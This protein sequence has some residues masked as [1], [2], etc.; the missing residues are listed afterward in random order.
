M[1]RLHS[2]IKLL[3]LIILA[4]VDFYGYTETC[5]VDVPRFSHFDMDGYTRYYIELDEQKR[6]TCI[7]SDDGSGTVHTDMV[8]SYVDGYI[9]KTT[10][11]YVDNVKKEREIDIRQGLAE[12]YQIEASGGN[13]SMINHWNDDVYDFSNG[14]LYVKWS[15]T[16]PH[17]YE[18]ADEGNCYGVSFCENPYKDKQTGLVRYDCF[19]WEARAVLE[20]TSIHSDDMS[21]IMGNIF[22]IE[23]TGR[24]SYFSYILFPFI[25]TDNPCVYTFDEY[26]ASS[27]LVENNVSYGAQNLATEEGIPWASQNGRG[28]GDSITIKADIRSDLLIAVRNGFQNNSKPY[29]YGENSRVKRMRVSY[30]ERGTSGE[31]LLEDVPDIQVLDIKDIIGDYGE[32]DETLTLEILDVYQGSKYDDLCIQSVLPYLWR[33]PQPVDGDNVV[34]PIDSRMVTENVVQAEN[35]V[36]KIAGEVENNAIIASSDTEHLDELTDSKSMVVVIVVA[37]LVGLSLV[38]FMILRK[39]F[40]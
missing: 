13:V 3:P 35:N 16:D 1:Q 6:I 4:S 14:I 26:E 25:I 10:W 30:K 5:Q 36:F 38:L 39:C 21:V 19:A 9:H 33:A 15:G 12:R 29:L 37:V 18:F 22:A 11:S 28:V 27:H 7:K 24:E 8:A 20:K 17:R 32:N 40:S 23:G 2:M 34:H 31:F